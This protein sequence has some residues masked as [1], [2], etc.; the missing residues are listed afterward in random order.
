LDFS[1]AD[2]PQKALAPRQELEALYRFILGTAYWL[3]DILGPWED[4]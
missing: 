4:D 2:H 1:G 3:A